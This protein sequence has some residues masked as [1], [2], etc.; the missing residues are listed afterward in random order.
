MTTEEQEPYHTRVRF[1][2]TNSRN[3]DWPATLGVQL[4]PRLEDT[5]FAL[6]RF[7]DYAPV[8]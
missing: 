6:S 5:G 7:P 1:F 8:R 4:L 3:I 2:F